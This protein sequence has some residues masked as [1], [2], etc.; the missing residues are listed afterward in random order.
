MP[1]TLNPACPLCG[2]SFRNRPLLDLHL[3][4]D[5]RQ[6]AASAEREHH[7]PG[8]AQA[9]VYRTDRPPDGRAATA[10][11]KR[12][13]GAGPAAAAR[14]W[15]ARGWA[16]RGWAARGWAARGWA[17]RGWAARALRRLRFSSAGRQSGA[18]SG[19]QR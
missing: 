15:A 17:A 11:A 6:R 3:R 8:R 9:P 10:T 7:D 13:R 14:G 5:H 16:A 1:S 19:W 18:G 4:E 12:G 2:L